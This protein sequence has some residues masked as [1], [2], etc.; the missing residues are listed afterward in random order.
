MF[1][2][3]SIE[4]RHGIVFRYPNLSPNEAAMDTNS[5]IAA[6]DAE[7]GKL[8]EVR[9]LLSSVNNATPVTKAAPAEKSVRRKLS[10]TAR[11]RIAEAQKKRWAA[12]KAAKEAVKPTPANKAVKETPAERV[13]VKKAPKRRSRLSPEAKKR[14][15]EAQRRRWAAVKAAKST[16]AKKA[17]KKAP[18]KK[19]PAKKKS[20][21]AP[22][23]VVSAAATEM[24][25]A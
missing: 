14:I 20:A 13:S 3:L 25:P 16:A 1:S 6:I 11:R 12:A 21:P 17:I 23:Q 10:P 19:A 18:V 24:N 5:I 9:A 7:I 8:Q 22:N 15:A 4:S 2:G